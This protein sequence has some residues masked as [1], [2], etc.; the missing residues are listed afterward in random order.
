[1][2]LFL[3]IFEKDSNMIGRELARE[4]WRLDYNTDTIKHFIF[5]GVDEMSL[6]ALRDPTGGWKW[7]GNHCHCGEY[8]IMTRDEVEQYAH[9]LSQLFHDAL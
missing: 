3:Y 8:W 9:T 5:E 4:M 1:M 2:G 7:R 6:T